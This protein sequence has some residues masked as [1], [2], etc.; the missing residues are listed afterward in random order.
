MP[1]RS[2]QY[3]CEAMRCEMS[4]RP[5]CPAIPPPCLMRAMPGAKSSSS[6]TTS[7]SSCLILKIPASICTARP[8]AFMKLCGRSSQAPLASWRPT[9]A[10]YF[11]SF[12][13]DT[14]FAAAN[15]STSQK[16]ALWRVRSYSLPG[17]PRP[18][19]SRIKLLLLFLLAAL[20]AR[21]L[22]GLVA[23]F[24]GALLGACSALGGSARGS[25]AFLGRGSLLG[26]RHIRRRHCRRDFLVL[27]D[28]LR[29]DDR[30][31]HGILVLVQRRLD[32]LRKGQVPHMDR[33]AHREAAQVDLD[34]FRQIVGQA[35]DVELVQDVVHHAALLL[36]AGRILGV[37]E[38]Q[39]HLHVDLLVLG[40]A[41]EVDVLHLHLERVH[42]DR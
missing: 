12:L 6:C 9:S 13:N 29:N 42:V 20:V 38:V 18:T 41:L 7:I 5:L 37:D 14:P 1:R 3:S 23:G 4:F 26:G 28:E 35:D 21:L 25:L 30:R 10:W 17:L 34:E 39:R 36:D 27:R 15:F 32:P 16:P 40:D 31:H 11:G 8:L 33:M 2:R 19:R 22:G 24:L